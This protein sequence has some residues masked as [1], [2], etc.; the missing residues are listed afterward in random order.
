VLLAVSLA[1]YRDEERMTREIVLDTETTGLDPLD[2]HRL[3]EV[4]CVELFN[5]LPTGRT[6]HA[7]LN[8]ERDMPT[9]AFQVHGLSAEFLSKH[10]CFAEAA[11]EFLAFIGDAR[12]IIH[13]AR[14]DMAFLNAELRRIGRD[15]LHDGRAVDTLALA[16]GK[17]PGAPCSLDAL[18][19]R[20][21][22]DNSARTKHGALLDCELLAEV[23]LNLM[24]GRQVDLGLLAPARVSIA[25]TGELR[26]RPPRPHAPAAAE[27]EAHAAFI[28][29]LENPVWLQ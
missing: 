5:Y 1:R 12:L 19:R 13:N 18:C 6:F 14:F 17:F 10:P 23:Y 24:G 29:K 2:G 16:L 21:A 26:V 7:Y 11:D 27:L 9:E 25:S 3:V 28:A 20:F 15:P 8:P 4:A 22:V